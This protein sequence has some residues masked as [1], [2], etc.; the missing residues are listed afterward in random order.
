[1]KR[2]KIILHRQ[3]DDCSVISSVCHCE[4]EQ[5]S[6]VA[7]QKKTFQPFNLSAQRAF[8]LAELMIVL[9]IMTII[10]AATMPILSKRA[11]VKAAA[12]AN[13][14]LPVKNEGDSCPPGNVAVGSDG[15]LLTCQGG[16]FKKPPGSGGSGQ[17]L[18]LYNQGTTFN[19]AN[20]ATCPLGWVEMSKELFKATENDGDASTAIYAR[21][22]YNTTQTCSTLY[23]YSDLSNP[24]NPVACPSGWADAG[25]GI[26][27]AGA[28]FGSRVRSCYKCS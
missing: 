4:E 8:S 2:K 13:I 15:T 5:S 17:T 18:Y 14:N 19:S 1:M 28:Y 23:T 20:V 22:C 26:Y 3:T 25:S 6:D 12:L 10:L 9:F 21:T 7:I 16:T 11:K 24:S 27:S